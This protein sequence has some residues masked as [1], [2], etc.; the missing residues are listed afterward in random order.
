MTDHLGS[1]LTSQDLPAPELCCARLD[2]ELVAVGDGWCPVDEPFGP[3]IRARAAA[4]LVPPRAIAER[5][6]AAWIF[7]VIPEPTRHQFCVDPASRTHISPSV[8]IHL[9]EVRCSP[10][11]TVSLGGFRVTTPLRTAVDLARDATFEEAPV[12]RLVAALLHYGRIDGDAVIRDL[13]RQARAP[14]MS[15]ALRRMRKAVRETPVVQSS[16]R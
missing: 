4:L 3:A 7:G 14:N 6:T 9:R 8:R 12:V 16:R 2:G 11:D 10:S 1:L 15:L 13:E 5:A